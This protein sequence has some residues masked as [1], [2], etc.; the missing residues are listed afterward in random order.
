MDEEHPGAVDF[1]VAACRDEGRWELSLLPAEAALRLGTLERALAQLASEVGT[2]GLVSLDDDFF[3]LLRVSGA[4]VRILLSDVGA[5]TESPLAMAILETLDLP[6]PDDDDPAQPAGDL[7][8]L[9]DLGLSAQQLGAM[10]DDT[11]LYPDEVLA[12]VADRLGFG[13]E[14]EDLLGVVSA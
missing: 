9:H 3:V 13:R 6:V 14:F 2:V 4:H 8:L 5:A 1:A 11:E 12:D 7:S 10:C